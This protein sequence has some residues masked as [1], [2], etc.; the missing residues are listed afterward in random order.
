MATTTTQ[1]PP[2]AHKMTGEERKVILASS[3]GTVFEWYDFY[4]YGTLATILAKQFFSGVEPQAAFIFTLLAFAA[5]FAVRPFGALL[6]GHIG[7][8]V[9]RKYTFIITITCM[10]LGTFLIGLLPSFATAG[11]VAPVLLIALRLIQGLALGGEYGGAAIY[12]AEHA[13]QGKRGLYTSWIQTTATLGL[14]L[15]LVVIGLLRG[16]MSPEAFASWGW[17]VPFLLSF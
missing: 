15:A 12:V 13:P 11:I 16:Y 5:G 1:S 9:G 3:V 2:Q 4:I 7:D 6:F 10:G 8:L 17:R 14:F